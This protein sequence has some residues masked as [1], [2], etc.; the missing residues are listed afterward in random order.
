MSADGKWSL[1]L[2]SP[3]GAQTMSMDLQ[4]E[5]GSLRGSIQG[6]QGAMDIT[7]GQADGDKLSWKVSL[8]QPMAMELEF[9]ATIDG[10]A[11]A[12]ETKMGTFGS[13]TFTGERA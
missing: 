13:A 11:M 8:T 3:M 10:D 5:D 1:T 6:P 2:N 4:T 12:G 9:T 7:E